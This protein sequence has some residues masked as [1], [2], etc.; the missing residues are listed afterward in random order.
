LESVQD[1]RAFETVLTHLKSELEAI[2]ALPTL[3]QPRTVIL[4]DDYDLASDMLSVNAGLLRDLRDLVRLYG[5]AGLHLWV[6]GYLER[7]SDPLIRH[8]LLKRSGVVLGSREGLSAFGVRAAGLSTD[9]LPVGRA[10]GVG[11]GAGALPIVQTAFVSD[12]G[13]VAAEISAHWAGSNPAAWLTGKPS[14][15]ASKPPTSG[16]PAIPLDIDTDGLL[17]DLMGDGA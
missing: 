4:I 10:Y 14:S 12:A 6:A 3:D 8:L 1:V 2:S 13:Q 9:T 7:P 5:G 17:D 16:K 11:I 15:A